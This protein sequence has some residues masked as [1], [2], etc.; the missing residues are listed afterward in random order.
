MNETFGSAP[1]DERS[2]AILAGTDAIAATGVNPGDESPSIP[3]WRVS[4]LTA[5]HLTNR[6]FLVTAQYDF[7]VI[8]AGHVQCPA[9]NCLNID[10]ANFC[11]ECRH[12]LVAEIPQS[13][14]P[15]FS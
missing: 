14:L 13:R 10:E 9:C 4:K 15:Q 6:Q 2:S 7:G 5:T 12:Q 11:R 1:A 8:P 3:E